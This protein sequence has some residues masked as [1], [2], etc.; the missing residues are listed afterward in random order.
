MQVLAFSDV[1]APRY[2]RMFKESLSRYRDKEIDLVMMAGDM[3][4]RSNV[5]NLQM[6]LDVLK[7][8][9]QPKKIVAVFGN[10]E[11]REYETEFRK[12]YPEVTWLNDE[13]IVIREKRGCLAI[14]GSRGSLF[15]PT[16][17]QRKYMPEVVEEYKKKPEVIRQL[18]KEAREQCPTVIYL[19]HYA[20]TWRTLVGESRKIWPYLGDPRIEKVLQEEGVKVAIHGHVHRGR[21]S[22]V[23]AYSMIIYNVA[24]PARGQITKI[25]ILMQLMI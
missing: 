17:W 10:E 11:Y 3:V 22:Y 6:V 23:H 4:D 5:E 9:V 14:V 8:H 24:L 19:S 25:K 16:S 13:Y 12:R 20:P 18:I 21:V 1:H 7:E 15:R 2:L